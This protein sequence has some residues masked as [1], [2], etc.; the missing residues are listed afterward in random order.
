MTGNKNESNLTGE[1]PTKE[2][3]FEAAINL[4]AEKGFDATSMREIAEAVGIK[5]A[6][7]Y[8]HYKGKDEILEKI[9]EYPLSRVMAIGEQDVGTEEFIATMGIEGF[10]DSS[11]EVLKSWLEDPYM[12]KIFRIIHI[13]LYHNQ[14]V[15][16]F[17]SQLWDTAYSFWESNFSIMIKQRLVKP[18][19]PK[20]LAMEFISF[21]Q[22]EF[23]DYFLLRYGDTPGSFS[24]EYEDRLKLHAEFIVNLIKVR[25][26]E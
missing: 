6:S 2:K 14:Q 22:N 25:D 26:E 21:F 18:F 7:L 19:D 17:Y 5:K 12:D 4:F 15:K 3:I 10:I 9:V 8:S 1:K 24:E 13:E 23:T 16:K 11:G 20:I